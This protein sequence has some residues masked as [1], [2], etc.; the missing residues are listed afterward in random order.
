ME[1]QKSKKQLIISLVLLLILILITVGISYA[2]FTYIGKGSTENMITTGNLTFVYDE[3]N[4]QGNGIK[5]SNVLPVSD[6]TGKQQTGNNNVFDFQVIATT[7]GAP[8]YYEVIGEK[9]EDSTLAEDVVKT[10]LT[11]VSGSEQTPVDKTL[12]NGKVATFDQL[13]ISQL[14]EYK[15]DKTLYQGTVS[16]GQEKYIQQF[17]LRMWLSETAT[18]VTDGEWDYN[19]KTFTIKIHVYASNE[20]LLEP[21]EGE[22]LPNAP[23]L[24]QGMIPVRYDGSKWVKADTSSEWYNYSKQEWANAVTVTETNRI[25]YMNAP[26]GTEILM[27]DIN[28]MW[29]WIPRYSY[30]IKSEDETNYYGKGESCGTI[31]NPTFEEYP[32]CYKVKSSTIDENEKNNLSNFIFESLKEQYPEFTLEEAKRIV[33]ESLTTGMIT[34]TVEDQTESMP[35]VSMIDV[36]NQENPEF[37]IEYETELD[38]LKTT[39]T[40]ETPGA[41]DI[42]FS[43]VDEKYI[44]KAQYTGEKPE[45]YMTHPAFI[46]GEKELTGI[47]YAKFEITGTLTTPCTDTSCDVSQVTIKP[48][49]T[50]LT[51][52]TISSFFYMAKSMQLNNGNIFGFSSSSGDIHMSKNSEWGS[53]AYLSQSKYGKYG[54]PNYEGTN[55]EI[56]QNKSSSYITGS[57]NG[58]PSTGTTNEQVTYDTPN[59]GYGASTTGT[60]YGVYDMSGGAYEYIMGNYNNTIGSYSGFSKM[61]ELKYY[62]LYTT[63]DAFTACDGGICY[64]HALSETSNWYVDHTVFVYSGSPWMTRGGN[65]HSYA[66]AGVFNF[67]NNSSGSAGSSF[68]ARFTITP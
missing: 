50:S 12:V 58:T 43:K 32:M 39:T 52:Q 44:G 1:N 60:I 46:F 34:I 21:L 5:L 9:K 61:P 24:V 36:Y 11:T 66:D 31:S 14:P 19:N 45:N 7:Q 33:E 27:D 42:R 64:G 41:I 15:G 18:G 56:Y 6:D 68:S 17:R 57:S 8:I 62:D 47:W 23:E 20:M 40:I 59:T 63:E 25:Q 51:N 48:G 28:T 3:K 38:S 37:I 13:P 67:Y 30:T 2:F 65:Y 4:A 53:V 54:N 26:T 16:E 10:Y 55:K 22:P 35:F 29:V 49:L